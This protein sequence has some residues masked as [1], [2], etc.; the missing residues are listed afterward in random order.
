MRNNR[1]ALH[2]SSSQTT[3]SSPTQVG[4]MSVLLWITI[5]FI[6]GGWPGGHTMDPR[7]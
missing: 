4:Y 6:V 3:A 2:D 7:I 5:S 1:A